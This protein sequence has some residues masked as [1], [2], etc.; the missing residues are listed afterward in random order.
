MYDGYTPE[1]EAA[2]R[3]LPEKHKKYVEY[4]IAGYS[5]SKSCM[6][7]GYGGVNNAQNAQSLE[8]RH[9][10]LRELADV[11]IK[12]NMMKDFLNGV[13]TNS[14]MNRRLD[15][16]ATQDNAEKVVKAM[17]TMDGET[18]KR[19][20]FYRDIINGTIKDTKRIVEKDGNGKTIKI[21]YEYM[22]SVDVKMR[23]RK[24]LDKLLG[25]TVLPDLGSLEFGDITVNIVDASK[26]EELADSRNKVELDPNKFNADNVEVVDGEAVIVTEEEVKT[27]KK[28]VKEV[29]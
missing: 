13:D 27:P 10:I 8:K 26:K 29:G 20:K 15:A 23:A 21:R 5:K 14:I 24:E 17:D 4:R 7:A 6:L 19:V 9:P 22:D 28:E 25:L 16:I 1:Q 18:A 2:Y 11:A 3:N 12:G